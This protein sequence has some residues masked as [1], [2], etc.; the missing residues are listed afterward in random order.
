MVALLEEG[1]PAGEVGAAYMAKELLREVYATTVVDQ[2]RRRLRRFYDHCHTSD[3]VELDR[4]ART[5]RRWEPQ[6]LAWHTTGLTNGP[7]EAVN[8]LVKKIP[9]LRW[10]HRW[11]KTAPYGRRQSRGLTRRR[12]RCPR[13]R[14]LFFRLKCRPRSCLQEPA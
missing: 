1:D 8:L 4:L 10:V 7:T 2:A 5:I 6:I 12:S 11:D 13:G 9:V 14:G 3:V